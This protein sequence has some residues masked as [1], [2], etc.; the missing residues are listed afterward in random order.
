MKGKWLMLK[1]PKIITT[2]QNNSPTVAVS[3]LTNF[4]L[5][6]C[7]NMFQMKEETL[8]II[9]M[10]SWASRVN[11]S[12][13]R[14]FFSNPSQ[15]GGKFWGTISCRGFMFLNTNEWFWTLI[16]GFDCLCKSQML[17]D[18]ISRVETPFTNSKDE[19]GKGIWQGKVPVIFGQNLTRCVVG[20]T[21]RKLH[22]KW[23]K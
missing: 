20:K 4:C 7:S 6:S 22:K 1:C 19:L 10:Y 9:L 8:R 3:L 23:L 2:H 12:R 21:H 11:T 16:A 17:L 18:N 5:Q 13:L 14:D 15:S